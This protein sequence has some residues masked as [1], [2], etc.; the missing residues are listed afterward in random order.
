MTLTIANWFPAEMV[1]KTGLLL[2]AENMSAWLPSQ[3][4]R[5]HRCVFPLS[6]RCGGAPR[7]WP[8]RQTGTAPPWRSPWASPADAPPAAEKRPA[9][10]G[11]H[12][13]TPPL[14]ARIPA[15]GTED[16]AVERPPVE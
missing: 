10:T 11:S 12:M 4:H 7:S 3:F 13:K 1:G 9:S 14:P 8:F 2:F 6:H 5:L 16:E 15:G